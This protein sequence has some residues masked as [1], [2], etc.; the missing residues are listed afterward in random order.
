MAL[1]PR[2]PQGQGSLA[3]HPGT[4]LWGTIDAASA[5]MMLITA[6]MVKPSM[7][8]L[9]LQPRAP[10]VAPDIHPLP[11]VAKAAPPGTVRRGAPFVYSN[12]EGH[13]QIMLRPLS[14]GRIRKRNMLRP[15]YMR[16]RWRATCAGPAAVCLRRGSP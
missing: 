3:W 8:L 15:S 11:Y 4:L 2:T 14:E 7:T 9:S 6:L 10:E 5:T 12:Q 13:S 1:R 16:R